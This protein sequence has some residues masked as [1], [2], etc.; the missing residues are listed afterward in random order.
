MG[1]IKPCPFCGGAAEL[2]ERL[3]FP[4]TWYVICRCCEISTFAFQTPEKALKRWNRRTE[5]NG[6]KV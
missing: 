6:E 5:K 4:E 3:D 1:E 2:R